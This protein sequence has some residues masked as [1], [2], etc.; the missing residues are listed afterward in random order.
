MVDHAELYMEETAPANELKGF[1]KFRATKIFLKPM[2][3]PLKPFKNL[4]HSFNLQ[5][6]YNAE[7]C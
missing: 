2:A 7:R 3:N 5:I 4:F 6:T 1:T